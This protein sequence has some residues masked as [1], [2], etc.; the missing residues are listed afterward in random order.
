MTSKTTQGRLI[1]RDSIDSVQVDII[2]QLY[3]YAPLRSVLDIHTYITNIRDD[4]THQ[5]DNKRNT[6]K[7]I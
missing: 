3:N 7:S 2:V 4:K 5:V 1:P 6:I